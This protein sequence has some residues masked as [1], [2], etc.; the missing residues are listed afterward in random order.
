M[1][2][3]G[4][5]TPVQT[6]VKR[7]RERWCY[8][9]ARR[10]RKA[11]S[12][13]TT[14][15]APTTTMKQAAIHGSVSGACAYA[16]LAQHSRLLPL[17]LPLATTCWSWATST[18]PA[19]G[20]HAALSTR[21][22]AVVASMSR[23]PPTTSLLRLDTVIAPSDA[24]PASRIVSLSWSHPDAR[25]GGSH[26]SILSEDGRIHTLSAEYTSPDSGRDC[27]ASLACPVIDA[28]A[29]TSGSGV[30]AVASASGLA[31]IVDKEAAQ[32]AT[33]VGSR[34]YPIVRR[35]TTQGGGISATAIRWSPN[36]DCVAI[37]S[38]DGSLTLWGASAS[39]GETITSP[40][41]APIRIVRWSPESWRI[42]FVAGRSFVV[43]AAHE[44]DIGPTKHR[45]A[46]LSGGSGI[47]SRSQRH[48]IP[49]IITALDWAPIPPSAGSC[50]PDTIATGSE[51]GM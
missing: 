48:T 25:D 15:N 45:D 23:A 49:S 26:V 33:D 37:G 36:G 22:R 18:Q 9:C 16:M 42:A 12:S 47:S 4:A 43:A 35:F 27:V 24:K 41:D 13:K 1:Y 11:S 46:R 6:A 29:Q 28:H 5:T 3:I 2:A 50:V 20:K 39:A 38:E 19:V 21:P 7:K 17:Q 34:E 31:C 32:N 44:W 14:A 30:I 51:D 8:N 10:W 40:S